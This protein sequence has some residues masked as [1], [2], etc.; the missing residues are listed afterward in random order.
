MFVPRRWSLQ[1][2][3]CMLIHRVQGSHLWRSVS[4]GF[5]ICTP[6]ASEIHQLH[7]WLALRSRMA[8]RGCQ[9]L[10]SGRNSNSRA[11]R[12]QLSKL[13]LRTMAR[14]TSYLCCRFILGLFQHLPREEA[15]LGGR[16]RPHNPRLWLL[17]RYCHSLGPGS[18]G[19]RST[20]LHNVQ[21]LW[22]LEQRRNLGPCWHSCCDDSIAGRGR[23]CPHV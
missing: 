15:T 16:N 20:S 21:Q 4:L 13:R 18:S 5:G 10:V 1:F 14:N 3:F 9:Y 11:D 19:R 7:N 8:N 6:T 23:C 2:Y 17:R 12:T 22:Q